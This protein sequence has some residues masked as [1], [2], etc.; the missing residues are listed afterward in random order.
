MSTEDNFWKRVAQWQC[1]RRTLLRGGITL[2][3]LSALG[4]RSAGSTGASKSG[5][6]L[7]TTQVSAPVKIANSWTGVA[8]EGSLFAAID[9]GIFKKNGLEVSLIQIVGTNAIAALISGQIQIADAGGGEGLASAVGGS[10]VVVV[11]AVTPV[12]TGKLYVTPD[13][14]SPSDLKGK[15]VGIALPGGTSD[16][17]LRLALTKVGLQPD[18]D[19]TFIATGSIENQAAALLSNAIQGTNINPS[20][21]SVKLE[22]QGIKPLLDFANM[23]LPPAATVTIATTRSY[24][25]A[26]ADVVQRYIDSIIEGTVLFRH[27]KALALKEMAAILKSDDQVGLNANYDYVNSDII[28]PLAPTPKPEL[29]KPLQDTLCNS[30]KIEAACNFDLT[31]VVD[32]SF[33]DSAVKR[34]LTKQQ[35]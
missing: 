34:G 27:D 16:Q 9:Q 7:A 6:P 8:Q 15:K 5:A 11:A 3:G 32:S 22:A 31:K 13:I 26:H 14:K 28:M 24:I 12:F 4:C 30:R 25:A 29:F 2:A 33:V 35:G 17:T 10:D 18:K 20:P 23:G 19:V 1:P 21:S